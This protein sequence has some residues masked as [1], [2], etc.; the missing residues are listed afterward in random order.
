MAETLQGVAKKSVGWSIALS[1]LLILAGFLA[2]ATP[3][4]AGVA[5]TAVVGWILLFSGLMHLVLA[6]HLHGAG[7]VLW[8]VLVGV[9]YLWVGGYMLSHPLLGLV[10]LT[11]ALGAY[12]LVKGLMEIVMWFQVRPLAASGWVLLDG[13]VSVVLSGLIWMHLPNSSTW[14]VGTL[15]GV[16]VLFSG[17]SRLVISLAARRALQDVA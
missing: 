2:L 3:L 1:V 11:L 8:E 15:V 12:L 7:A 4:A 14:V 10:S 16:A 5:V 17:V 6:W 9:V 13:V